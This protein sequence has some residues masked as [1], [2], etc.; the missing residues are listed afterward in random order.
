ML[1]WKLFAAAAGLAAGTSLLI[2]TELK[3]DELFGYDFSK[4]SNLE[5]KRKAKIANG[6]LSLDGKGDFAYVPHSENMHFEKKGMTL[7]ATVRLNYS[8]HLFHGR[9]QRVRG[10]DDF[11]ASRHA[12]GGERAAPPPGG[13]PIHAQ[14]CGV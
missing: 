14:R 9:S 6:V 10:A 1:K 7:A 12:H 13:Y 4:N 8:V 3:S 5:L 2:G 11:P